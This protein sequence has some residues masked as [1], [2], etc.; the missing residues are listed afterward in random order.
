MPTWGQ[1]LDRI[2]EARERIGDQAYDVVRNHYIENLA[3]LTGNDT[4]VYTTGWTSGS[5]GTASHSISQQ[6]VEGF[7]EAFSGLIGDSLDL[8]LHSPGGSPE[9]AE[10]VVEY[11]RRALFRRLNSER[12]GPT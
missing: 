7:M 8:I 12:L 1:I 4:I 2:N 6:D 11:I 9:D 3:E 5:S 10:H